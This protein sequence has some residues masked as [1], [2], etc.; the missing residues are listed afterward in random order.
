MTGFTPIDSILAFTGAT[1]ASQ[2]HA[3]FWNGGV[4]VAVILVGVLMTAVR[5][6]PHGALLPVVLHLVVATALAFA[7]GAS[8]RA[9][10]LKRSITEEANAVVAPAVAGQRPP[11]GA[12]LPAGFVLINDAMHSLS[13]S[14]IQL[15]KRDFAERPF[16]ALVVVNRLAAEKFDGD[17]A[18]QARLGTFLDTC[19][20]AA[21]QAWEA[22][23]PTEQRDA[24]AVNT[25]AASALQP[26]YATLSFPDANGEAVSCATQW[27]GLRGDIAAY[28]R[29]HVTP[30]TDWVSA[31]LSWLSRTFGSDEWV[32]NNALRNYRQAVEPPGGSQLDPSSPSRN[33]LDPVAWLQGGASLVLGTIAGLWN[34]V[35]MGQIVDFFQRSAYVF[36]GYAMMAAYAVFPIM[37]G[38][39]LWPGQFGRFATYL[40]LLLSLKMWPVFWAMI[41]TAHE[42]ILPV[43]VASGVVDGPDSARYP[44]LLQFIT[45]VTVFSVPAMVS[46]LF[47]VASHR[48]GSNLS[49]WKPGHIPFV[50]TLV[51][52]G[53]RGGAGRP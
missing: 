20:G 52:G 13:Q 49:N 47:G 4:Y 44:A 27:E 45:A 50:G 30:A 22:A 16:A 12:S 29:T 41:A 37:L 42:K 18:L 10:E 17:P 14:M 53:A 2:L 26:Y 8:S 34:P 39:A 7:F 36:Y 5:A 24:F 6:M 1:W 35:V 40:M 11:T 25:P 32:V 43:F 23:T 21:L 46:M 28:A 15:I 9:I 38:F 48:I 3:M 19:Y 33:W 51:T 31:T